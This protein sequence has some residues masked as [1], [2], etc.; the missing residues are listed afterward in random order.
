MSQNCNQVIILSQNYAWSKHIDCIDKL[1]NSYRNWI[2]RAMEQKLNIHKKLQCSMYRALTEMKDNDQMKWNMLMNK[3]LEVIHNLE[4]GYASDI[5]KLLQQKLNI[6]MNMMKKY[7]QYTFQ[8]LIKNYEIK[9][10]MQQRQQHQNQQQPQ[11][12]PQQQ[13]KQKPQTNII[14]I[15]NIT[16][17]INTNMNNNNNN[18]DVNNNNNNNINQIP[19]L[20]KESV[21][22]IQEVETLSTLT[23]V[24]SDQQTQHQHILNNTSK[25]KE[26]KHDNNIKFDH[27]LTI[28][29]EKKN[30]HCHNNNNFKTDNNINNNNDNKLCFGTTENKMMQLL[31]AL[32]A[33]SYGTESV[34]CSQ[35]KKYIDDHNNNNNNNNFYCSG[36]MSQHNEIDGYLWCP[37]CRKS[38]YFMNQTALLSHLAISHQIIFNK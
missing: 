17:I 29:V 21:D 31:K 11:Q 8:Q 32:N 23:S 33:K 22:H 30:I 4:Y 13:K 38:Q 12:Q 18:N 1:D 10:K 3:H 16:N 25:P 26:S 28:K 27:D 15:T 20:E 24:T 19:F 5:T 36:S 7:Y 14:N 37:L 34:K 2:E 6:H 35:D 9:N